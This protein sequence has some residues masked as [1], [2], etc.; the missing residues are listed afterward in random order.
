MKVQEQTKLRSQA[1]QILRFYE[2]IDPAFPLPEAVEIM[3]PFKDETAWIYTE[4]FYRRF[5][6]DNNPRTLIFGINPGRFGGGITGIPFTDPIRLANSC[7][8]ENP[9][10]KV[11]E[12]SSIFVYELIEAYGGAGKFYK[13]FLITALS[14]LGFTKN[15]TN[16]NYYDDKDLIKSAESFIAECIAWQRENIQSP[17]YC[18]CL[19]EG[20]NY[21]YFQK[22]NTKH[23]FFSSISPL[24]HPRW[25]MQYRRKKLKDFVQ[26]YLEK[27]SA[28]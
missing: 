5:Y 4:Q 2:S 12:L 20:T 25:I 11:A 18:F 23:G 9:F 10:K 27:L 13:D 16:L 28:K 3:N 17:A 1:D 15:G 7:G 19:G 22:L 8:I 24:P 14:P 21:N 26:L 6:S